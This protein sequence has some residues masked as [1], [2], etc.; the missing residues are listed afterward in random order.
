MKLAFVILTS[1]RGVYRTEPGDGMD[2]C[3][4]CGCMF[5]RQSRARYVSATSPSNLKVR[6]VDEGLPQCV[7]HTSSKFL[8]KLATIEAAR[9]RTCLLL[10]FDGSD[11]SLS[12]AA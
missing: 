11:M 5:S 8:V 7:T 3:G 1:H 4:A 2:L 12:K 10:G 9:E 6:L